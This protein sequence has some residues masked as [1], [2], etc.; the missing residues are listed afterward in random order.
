MKAD[1]YGLDGKKSKSIDLPE[2]FNENYEPTL[3][4]RAIL[5]VL[6]HGRQKYGAMVQAGKNYS[7]KLSKRRR[8]YRGSYGKG[9]SRTPRKIM[10]RRGRQMGWVGALAPGTVG[11]RRAH[12]A[13]PTRDW[14]L[15]INVK[16]RKKAIRSALSGT[17]LQNKI[18]VVDNKLESLNKTKEIQST[19]KNLGLSI[20]VVKRQKAGRG[21]TRGRRIHYKKQALIIVANK[22]NLM[23]AVNNLPGY[24]IVDAKSVNAQLLTLGHEGA[25]QCLFTEAAIERIGKEKLFQ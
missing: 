23:T 13:K 1:V 16:E 3:I 21:K 9:I 17:V 7:A 20:E 5:V 4:K 25:R 8:D 14:D 10:W 15:K 19:L 11:G 22:C 6:S 18:M 12:P 2:Q 24:D